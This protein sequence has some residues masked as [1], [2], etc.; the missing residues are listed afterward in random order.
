MST[1]AYSVEI[2]RPPEEVFAFLTDP[3]GYPR[4]QPSLVSVQPHSPGP[5]ELGSRATEVRR[6]LG[7][8]LETTWT[9]VEHRPCTRSSI[10]CS[11]GPVPFRGTFELEP[12]PGGTSFTWTVETRGAAARLGG[13]VAGLAT[14][15]ELAANAGRL[16]E[17]LER[18]PRAC[19]K[20]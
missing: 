10:E 1:Y 9:C 8:E 3:A 14:R 20:G 18:E 15:R 2:Q 7:R 6:F 4:W 16:K 13:P 11:D 19:P 12:S 5:L 17:L